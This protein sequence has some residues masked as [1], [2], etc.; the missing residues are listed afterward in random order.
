MVM[1]K[2]MVVVTS[3]KREVDFRTL[4]YIVEHDIVKARKKKMNRGTYLIVTATIDGT[5]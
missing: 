5:D 2:K 3:L 4:Y 1:M